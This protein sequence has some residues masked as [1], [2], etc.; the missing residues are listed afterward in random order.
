MMTV[1]PARAEILQL[2][3]SFLRVARKF[4]DYN[5][6]EYAKRRTIDGF[7]HNKSLSDSSSIAQAFSDAKAE[8]QIAERQALVYSL[9][10]PKFRS[11][12]DIPNR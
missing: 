9:Y 7:H 2:Y 12:M 11:I 10:A 1:A 5:I 8:F 6:R 4:P 3:R